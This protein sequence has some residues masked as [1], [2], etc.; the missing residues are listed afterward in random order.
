MDK[1]TKKRLDEIGKKLKQKQRENVLMEL[2]T[3]VD[4]LKHSLITTKTI[5]VDKD[6]FVKCDDMTFKIDRKKK[7][8]KGGRKHILH[9][10]TDVFFSHFPDS[11]SL[12]YRLE[13]RNREQVRGY[14]FL[15]SMVTE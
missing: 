14:I 5:V 13:V 10:V 11:N 8:L 2:F 7:V 4:L 6:N 15:T 12:L 1:G 9:N 3:A